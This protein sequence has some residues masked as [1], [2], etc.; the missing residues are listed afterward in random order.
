MVLINLLAIA[1][2]ALYFFK[3][4]SPLA[5]LIMSFL[6]FI[7]MIMYWFILP[8]VIFRQSAT[9]KDSFRAVL[10]KEQFAI[11]N[12]RGHKS[13]DWSAFST[14]MESPH[15]FHLYFTPQSFFIIPKESFEGEEA[16]E[17]RKIL[18]DK[19]HKPN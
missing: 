14:W 17:A 7:L 12:D 19:I 9:F 4:I 10:G 18:K 8:Q 16:Q 3:Q 13:W 11:E 2:A 6:W 15:F 5:F 1:S